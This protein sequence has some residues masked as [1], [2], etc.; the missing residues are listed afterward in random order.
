MSFYKATLSAGTQLPSDGLIFVSVNDQDKF[1]IISTIRGFSELG[2]D[3]IA[4][5]G[6]ATELIKNGMNV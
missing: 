4:T 1:N 3:L 6:T 5:K 2:F